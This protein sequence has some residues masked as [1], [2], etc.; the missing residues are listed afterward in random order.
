M[1]MLITVADAQL[2][3]MAAGGEILEPSAEVCEHTAQQFD[4]QRA[5]NQGRTEWAAILRKLDS[6]DPSFRD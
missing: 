2:R 5:K 6:I 1:K 4:K 3:L